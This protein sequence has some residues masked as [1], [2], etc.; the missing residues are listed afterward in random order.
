[1]GRVSNWLM[2][3]IQTQKQGPIC[4]KLRTPHLARVLWG[5]QAVGELS[6]LLLTMT[7]ASNVGRVGS[8]VQKL[9][10]L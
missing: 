2:K 5:K 10:S 6:T 9:A 1:M 7:N 4:R 3:L 8:T